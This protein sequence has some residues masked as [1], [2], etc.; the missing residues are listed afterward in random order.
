M[1]NT[2]V[3]RPL[4]LPSYEEVLT[5][6][7]ISTEQFSELKYQEYILSL[8][9]RISLLKEQES[10]FMSQL[11]QLRPNLDKGTKLFLAHFDLANKFLKSISDSIYSLTEQGDLFPANDQWLL[12]EDSLD[13]LSEQVR[14]MKFVIANLYNIG[15]YQAVGYYSSKKKEIGIGQL[16]DEDLFSEYARYDLTP[17]QTEKYFD[18][19]IKKPEGIHSQTL[20]FG[21]GMATV[22][23]TI[24][25]AKYEN[26]NGSYLFGSQ[27][28]FENNNQAQQLQDELHFERFELFDENVP[29][30]LKDKMKSDPSVIFAEP[31]GNSKDLPSINLEDILKTP[32]NNR[33]R[34]IIIDT[35]LSGP[36]FNYKDV[37]ADLDD[38]SVLILV[39][40]LQKLYQEG[41]GVASAGM[42]TILTRDEALKNETVTKMKTFRGMLGTNITPHN[43][44]LI[45]K[46]S[47]E[48]VTKYAEQ[49][50]KNVTDFA[51]A[52]KS[53][54]YSIVEKIATAPIKAN[55][56]SEASVF[57]I[58]FKKDC[59]QK[60]I[61]KVVT[62][63]KGRDIQIT[64]GAS[65]GFRNTRLMV[66]GGD[67]FAVRV[68]PG[69]ENTR[70]LA[71]LEEIFE[72]TLKELGQ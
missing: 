22:S 20:L 3:A 51:S 38:K 32:T 39:A 1:A 58:Q 53:K 67:E 62:K 66:I 64:D 46:I 52:L 63:S 2:E 16:S 45:Q 71:I 55:G 29:D 23:T 61:D 21:S 37:L 18:N 70:Q 65:F 25:L 56:V 60:F 9:K 33:T 50:G 36:N 57:Y 11:E 30:D 59:G 41:D 4:N 49:I 72:E 7:K 34:L 17:T 47:P 26:P 19:Q 48:N 6:S 10:Y 8:E 5:A 28:Y 43:L 42:A 69:I 15:N 13:G 35:T 14:E 44:K 31:I 54:Q 24:A 27:M 12:L 68:C 40:S